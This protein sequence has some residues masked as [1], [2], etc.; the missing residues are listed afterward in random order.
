[1]T[2]VWYQRFDQEVG[3]RGRGGWRV[4]GRSGRGSEGVTRRALTVRLIKVTDAAKCT[5]SSLMR[6]ANVP[7]A[8]V[9][10]RA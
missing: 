7:D 8:S 9:K 4:C 1:M 5:E 10:C 3:M 6:A 2:S